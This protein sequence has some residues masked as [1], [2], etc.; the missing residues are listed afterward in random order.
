M[1]LTLA[2]ALPATSQKAHAEI[3]GSP[4]PSDSFT[5]DTYIYACVGGASIAGI[6]GGIIGGVMTGG[7]GIIPGFLIGLAAGGA[8]GCAIAIVLTGIAHGLTIATEE[9]IEFTM[10]ALASL[11]GS[12]EN[13]ANLTDQQELDGKQVVAD[14]YPSGTDLLTG[15]TGI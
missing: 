2:I 10:N 13:Y 8:P 15:T 3:F 1:L 6:T 11:E 7:I 4:S 12:T 5:E 9:L 14:E